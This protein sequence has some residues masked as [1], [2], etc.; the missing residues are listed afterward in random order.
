M[1]RY[2]VLNFCRS[3][4]NPSKMLTL[5]SLQI[6]QLLTIIQ[7]SKQTL[8]GE[9]SNSR[10]RK[11]LEKIDGTTFG[12]K[13]Q[14]LSSNYSPSDI[15]NS[16]ACNKHTLEREY[17]V[18]IDY[19]HLKNSFESYRSFLTCKDHL[20]IIKLLDQSED[21][22]LKSV[23]LQKSIDTYVVSLNLPDNRKVKNY[24]DCISF[25]QK[26]AFDIN[27]NFL[28][29]KNYNTSKY[30]RDFIEKGY[31]NMYNEM[32]KLWYAILNILI[33]TSMDDYQVQKTPLISS[34]DVLVYFI[35]RFPYIIS[36]FGNTSILNQIETSFDKF[37]RYYESS[38]T[39]IQQNPISTLDSIY[40]GKWINL[41]NEF[42]VCFPDNFT[43]KNESNEDKNLYT[44]L[45]LFK[46]QKRIFN[47]N[48][49]K[50]INNC[51][52][53]SQNQ[54]R[55]TGKYSNGLDSPELEKNIKKKFECESA[56]FQTQQLEIL[57]NLRISNNNL[58]V[59]VKSPYNSSQ[60]TR[61]ENEGQLCSFKELC[62]HLTNNIRNLEKICRKLGNT[63]IQ[64]PH[65]KLCLKHKNVSCQLKWFF[66]IFTTT[67]CK[68]SEPKLSDICNSIIKNFSTF[69]D[70]YSFYS[71]KMI[72][73]V[74]RNVCAIRIQQNNIRACLKRY[75]FY[76]KCYLLKLN[77]LSKAVGTDEKI[78]IN[79][80]ITVSCVWFE[81]IERTIILQEV[82]F[83]AFETFKNDF[84]KYLYTQ[85]ILSEMNHIILL[86]EKRVPF[87]YNS[88]ELYAKYFLKTIL[89][90]SYLRPNANN[91]LYE[92][93]MITKHA[94]KYLNLILS[95]Y[96][97][98]LKN[99]SERENLVRAYETFNNMFQSYI[100]LVNCIFGE[101]NVQ[102]AQYSSEQNPS[103]LQ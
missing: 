60:Q 92:H 7:K 25:L 86:T 8:H 65:E 14:C 45:M 42:H 69:I 16:E 4:Q 56:S 29:I 41:Q 68:N 95:S 13:V 87:I 15:T 79:N 43:S 90:L 48:D 93:F 26:F 78:K 54:K 38:F 76:L 59:Y 36:K 82:L 27:A 30:N 85:K 46:N 97:N 10:K 51:T 2:H 19:V 31:K 18:I 81:N 74:F 64:L 55:D 34:F 58:L 63:Y 6:I 62:M 9:N 49:L 83:Y 52:S 40:K 80:D 72:K 88:L 84:N 57:N 11:M 71:Q 33:I 20:Q 98:T 91:Q 28:I 47:S 22:V 96:I 100:S 39:E 44:I 94:Y 17:Q 101:K 73:T 77:S 67:C 24:K 1:N 35:N 37:K 102:L 89:T 32:V 23:N 103:L 12:L 50:N 53:N 99:N 5:L 3:V 75:E 61:M 21:V 70:L 66:S